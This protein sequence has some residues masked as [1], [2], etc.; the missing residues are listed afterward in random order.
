[1][2]NY[3]SFYIK[4][5]QEERH[6]LENISKAYSYLSSKYKSETKFVILT[7]SFRIFLSIFFSIYGFNA[8]IFIPRF[9]FFSNTNFEL[10]DVIICD[11]K[12]FLIIKF[13]TKGKIKIE[14]VE[15]VL[16]KRN[17]TI[18]NTKLL[19]KLK[20]FDINSETIY[21]NSGGTFQK[22]INVRT[23]KNDMAIYDY[24]K[25]LFPRN[26][27]VI[28]TFI[29][30]GIVC[31][32]LGFQCK[33]LKKKK[34]I[35]DSV[36]S[37]TLL[38]M[39]PDQLYRLIIFSKQRK[40]KIH[41]KAIY[42]GGY[43]IGNSF[44]KYIIEN[45]LAENIYS[46]YGSSETGIL[47]M[48]SLHEILSKSNQYLG[49]YTGNIKS[50]NENLNF[51]LKNCKTMCI[52]GPSVLE[53]YYDRSHNNSTKCYISGNLYHDTGDVFYIDEN[54]GDM[55]IQGTN[56]YYLDQIFLFECYIDSLPGVYK[57]IYIPQK[58]KLFIEELHGMKI[59]KNEIEKNIYIQFN[60]DKLQ[61]KIGTIPRTS[62]DKPDRKIMK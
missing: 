16:K 49:Y 1:M 37:E 15:T 41:A 11:R 8:K 19:D 59:N 30:Y 51:V 2:S 58:S 56:R 45:V 20:N 4:N 22:K 5:N 32:M 28:T 61:I 21:N 44:V 3:L 52:S 50:K 47:F 38:F 17:T 39:S 62:N 53:N 46:G 40:K 36:D 26:S 55:W 25:N 14:T 43:A 57:C 60:I 42:I 7:K 24:F 18:E 23:L 48:T 54:S 13:L 10:A 27:K 34:E 6:I 12:Y 33:I 9:S 35:F 31:T 29:G